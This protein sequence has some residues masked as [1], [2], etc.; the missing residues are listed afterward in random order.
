MPSNHNKDKPW[1]TEDIDK[2]KV[3]PFKAED[4]KGGPLTE[5]SSF[6]ILFPKYR[7]VYLVGAL[8]SNSKN[9]GLEE[10]LWMLTISRK[11]HGRLSRNRSR[12]YT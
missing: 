6:E 12:R 11:R 5:E 7:E 4:N 3:E 8:K 1:D 2:W 9:H 10:Q